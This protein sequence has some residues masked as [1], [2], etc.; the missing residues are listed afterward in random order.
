MKIEIRAKTE[1]TDG[2]V[3]NVFHESKHIGFII[4][5]E[6][7]EKPY[8]LVDMQGDTCNTETLE[9]AVK[10][11]CLK[12]IAANMPKK[13]RANFLAALVAMKLC[14]EL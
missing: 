3:H 2:V 6:N 5:T 4:K 10:R 7:K 1:T 14:G 8:T 12:Q 13:E 9:N 11:A